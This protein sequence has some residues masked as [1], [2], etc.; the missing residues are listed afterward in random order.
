[1]KQCSNTDWNQN[2]DNNVVESIQD[3]HVTTLLVR[4]IYMVIVS[5]GVKHLPCIPSRARALMN[6]LPS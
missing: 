2:G 6:A 1:M 4:L 5:P 3:Q